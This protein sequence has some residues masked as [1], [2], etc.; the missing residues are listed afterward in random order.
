MSLLP[1]ATPRSGL[2]LGLGL[3]AELVAMVGRD[4]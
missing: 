4:T 3:G 2:G 1:G